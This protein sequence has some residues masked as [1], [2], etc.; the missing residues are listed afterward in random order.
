[1]GSL[2]LRPEKLLDHGSQ[3]P[4][5]CICHILFLHSPLDGHVGCGQCL[6]SVDHAPMNVGVSISFSVLHLISLRTQVG[7]ARSR[8]ISIF[9]FLRNVLL[10]CTAVAPFW[11][12]HIPTDRAQ[13]FQFLRILCDTCCRL[14]FNSSRPKA[15]PSVLA[16]ARGHLRGAWSWSAPS[17]VT[18]FCG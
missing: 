10:F 5:A 7:V 15:T 12:F 13:G 4:V 14:V 8:G 17:V 9:K 18:V 3:G 6:A 11:P 16:H 2:A 1:M